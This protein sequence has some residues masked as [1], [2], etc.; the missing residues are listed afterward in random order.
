MLRRV[1]QALCMFHNHPV[2]DGLGVF[3]PFDVVSLLLRPAQERSSRCRNSTGPAPES[4]TQIE[5]A[6]RADDPH[7]LCH[8]DLLLGNFIDAGTSLLIID[9]EYAGLGNRYFDLGNFAAHNQLADAE[10]RALLEHYFGEARP[11]DLRRL[12][13]MRMVSDL[14]EATWGYL[15]SAI[16]SLHNPQ[17]YLD[18]GRRFLDRFWIAFS[19]AKD[20]VP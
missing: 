17:H 19:T 8:N 1:A 12:Q 6:V 3:S 4:L 16:S 9:W 14:R 7:C 5:D 13:L 20:A 10:E 2:S 18:Y 11:E 15:Q